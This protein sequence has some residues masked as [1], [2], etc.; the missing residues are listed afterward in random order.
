MHLNKIT[1]LATNLQNIKN[2]CYVSCVM[3]ALVVSLYPFR[4]E[5]QHDTTDIYD[6]IKMIRHSTTTTHNIMRKKYPK[7]VDDLQKSLRIDQ[8]MYDADEY[9]L[10]VLEKNTTIKKLFQLVQC[11]QNV[12]MD[13]SRQGTRH[14][15]HP[16]QYQVVF[17]QDTSVDLIL[18]LEQNFIRID[19]FDTSAD[20]KQVNMFDVSDN[21][22]LCFHV[23]RFR[24]TS[25]VQKIHHKVHFPLKLSSKTLTRESNHMYELVAIVE[26]VGQEM[27]IGH[28]V[29]Y[30]KYGE[31]WW[32]Y[33]DIKPEP[34]N[35]SEA[36]IMN[37][38]PYILIYV[39]TN[40]SI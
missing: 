23:Q 10:Y 7:F 17:D 12:R 25:H 3:Q 19:S 22:I 14:I 31:L 5:F 33:D 38:N 1:P 27:N 29:S 18:Y 13:G 2:A 20:L 26:H 30:V 39:R 28:Y 37:R 35:K 32:E 24:M 34:V 21:R 4:Q 9:L 11:T 40:E 6:M 15:F 8:D 16:C 36:E